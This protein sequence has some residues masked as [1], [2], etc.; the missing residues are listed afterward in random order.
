[1][2][3]AAPL[4]RR[5]TRL[6][7]QLCQ[8]Q[9]QNVDAGRIQALI[10]EIADVERQISALQRAEPRQEDPRFILDGWQATDSRF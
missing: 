10:D 8:A 2:K 5:F 1:V 6:Q 4:I 7:A 9:A 3:D